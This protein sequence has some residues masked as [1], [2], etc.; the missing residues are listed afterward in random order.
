MIIKCISNKAESLPSDLLFSK[1]SKFHLVVDKYYIVYAI[2]LYK[3][4]SWYAIC[5]QTYRY[6]PFFHPSPLFSI[7]N[8]QLSRYWIDSY[9]REENSSRNIFAYAEWVNDPYYYDSLTDADEKEVKI[10]KHYKSLMDLEF[11]D[12]SIPD[13]DKVTSLDDGWLL[14]PFCIDA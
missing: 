1:N 2:M 3:G 5:D 12:P 9:S 7:S 11:P 6:Y 10:F 13:S 14:C 4:Y 8:G